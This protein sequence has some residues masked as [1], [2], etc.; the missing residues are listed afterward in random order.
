[1]T[2]RQ[3]KTKLLAFLCYGVLI[4]HSAT[5]YAEPPSRVARLSDLAGIV[6]FSPAGEDD[7]VIATRNRPLI[8]GDRLWN[9]KNSESLLELNGA[10]FCVGSDTSISFVNLDDTIAQVQ[11]EQG[12]LLLHI[13]S[14]GKNQ[15]YEIDTPQLA[16]SIN[17]TGEYRID[18][19]PA[20]KTTLVSIRKGEADAYDEN[21]AFT[22]PSGSSYQF[23]G[24]DLSQYQIQPLIA[25]DHL[26]QWCSNHIPAASAVSEKHVSENVIGSADLNLY[27]TWKPHAQYGTIWYPTNVSADW[28]PYR[29]GYWVWCDA[30]GWTWVG[31]ESWGFAPYHYGRW[32]Y[33]DNGW[34]WVPGSYQ[35]EAYYA[36]AL[37]VFVEGAAFEDVAWFPLGPDD[38]YYPAYKVNQ[39]YFIKM[40]SGNT[41]INKNIIASAFNKSMPAFN[42]K[43]LQIQKGITAISKSAF[44]QAQPAN[45]NMINIPPLKKVQ[46][47]SHPT[48]APQASSILGAAAITGNK[49]TAQILNQ[50]IIAKSKPPASALSFT[51]KQDQL[52]QNK[53]IPLTAAALS[54]LQSKSTQSINK[55]KIIIPKQPV[56]LKTGETVSPATSEKENPKTHAKGK[57]PHHK[58]KS[59]PHNEHEMTVPHNERNR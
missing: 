32:L 23:S 1:M 43:N 48:V 36:P 58:D 51:A 18:V 17:Q 26:Y 45:K 28:A 3:S 14:L 49:P 46:A 35:A 33:V 7:W 52:M 40:N 12:S 8:T 59:V 53:G 25:R 34:C 56:L 27:G 24:S 16:L 11:I 5:L 15:S 30:L 19:A 50:P 44:V 20:G 31:G 47:A 38:I 10:T 29:E 13:T 9:D 22:L 54:T 6:S 2:H 42:F 21:N 41:L 57:V 55:I 4:V 39:E 37:V